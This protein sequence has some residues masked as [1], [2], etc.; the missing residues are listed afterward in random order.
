MLSHH[1]GVVDVVAPPDAAPE[2]V[3][4][5]PVILLSITSGCSGCMLLISC[6]TGIVGA[7]G[8]A[9]VSAFGV[10]IGEFEFDGKN[11]S[12]YFT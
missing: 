11:L 8:F 2:L 1:C 7:G 10:V 6:S 5:L 4:P 9:L 3:V 12:G